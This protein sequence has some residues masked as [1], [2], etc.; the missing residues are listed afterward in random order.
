VSAPALTSRERANSVAVDR[1]L[2]AAP[3]LVDVRPAIEVVPGMT[4][5]AV[6]AAGAPLPWQEHSGGQRDA[7][8]RGALAEGLASDAADADRRLASGEITLGALHDHGCVGSQA[9]VLTASTPV[10]VVANAEHGNVAFGHLCERSGR[11]P[12]FLRDV[13][14]P[15]LGD[16]VRHADGGIP[17][18]PIIGRALAM[19]DELH[20]RSAAATLLL[21]RELLPHLLAVSAR[22][23]EEMRRAVDVMV[24]DD[25]LFAALSTC[26]SKAT[27]DAARDVDGSGIVTAMT[28]SC[29]EFAIRVSGLGDRWFR[30]GLPD[31]GAEPTAGDGVINETAGLGGFAQAAAFALQGLHAGGPEQMIDDTLRMYRVTAAEHP[32]YR[33]PALGFRGVPVGIDV[34]RVA[35]TR[36]RPVLGVGAAWGQVGAGLMHAPL[37]CF[38]EAARELAVT[39][40]EEEA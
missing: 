15:V 26:A 35:A 10:F 9:G 4:A 31:A 27:A 13:V 36:V 25:A 6:L 39:W 33:I 19:G 5:D 23:P 12:A 37:A 11:G 40:V 1:M 34:E 3:V 24:A 18:R 21:L 32:A 28:L 2:R 17:L 7:V 38:D 16:A 29:R 8:I 20:S 14:A 30:S 22:R